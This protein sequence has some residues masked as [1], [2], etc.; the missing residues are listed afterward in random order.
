MAEKHLYEGILPALALPLKSDLAID[1]E[2]LDRHVRYL[3]D[4]GIS[5]IV[6]NAHSG[7]VYALS[8]QERIDVIKATVQGAKGKVPVVAGV[9]AE[10]TEGAIQ[11]A[12]DAKKAGA[13]ALIVFLP[14]ILTWITRQQRDRDTEIAFAWHHAIDKAANM[15]MIVFQ[16]TVWSQHHLPLETLLKLAEIKNVVGIKYASIELLNYM[17]G[18]RA[19]KAV[20]PDIA[21]YQPVA[22]LIYPTAA[23]V[24]T[25]GSLTGFANF[26]PELLVQ[27]YRC[28]KNGDFNGA[29]ALQ[30]RIGP[31]SET[32]YAYGDAFGEPWVDFEGRYKVATYLLG[33]FD[34]PDMRS[35]FLPVR[36]REVVKISRS[37]AKSGVN[38]Q[39]ST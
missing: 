11:C 17:A 4:S 32:I 12:V 21:V 1:F 28:I 9:H 16:Y 8:P 23:L 27:Q 38:G 33:K 36:D 35:P 18:Y 20:R 13:D 3:A 7:E 19:L 34:R 30:E 6:S 10:T 2:A 39:T 5:A 14:H 15:P 29:A 22:G 37:S 24:G 26:C 31:L 25:D